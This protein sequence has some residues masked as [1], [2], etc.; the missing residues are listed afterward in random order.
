MDLNIVLRKQKQKH[1]DYISNEVK[2]AKLVT[3]VNLYSIL[4]LKNPADIGLYLMDGKHELG[5]YI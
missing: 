4:K 2:I 1:L 5:Y 3:K